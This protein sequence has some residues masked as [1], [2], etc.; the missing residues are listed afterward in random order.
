MSTVAT[1]LAATLL[2]ACAVDAPPDLGPDAAI[3]APTTTCANLGCPGV[4]LSDRRCAATG[5][6]Y[7]APTHG[8]TP[9]RCAPGPL[10]CAE[11]GCMPIETACIGDTCTCPRPDGSGATVSCSRA[12][13]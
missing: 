13:L 5:E 4:E 10:R 1:I 2:T 12:P 9:L 11:L 3:E 7:C 8:A 6:C